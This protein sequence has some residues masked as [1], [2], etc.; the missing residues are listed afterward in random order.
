MTPDLPTKKPQTGTHY[1]GENVNGSPVIRISMDCPCD[2]DE[3]PFDGRNSFPRDSGMTCEN[4]GCTL[5]PN[6]IQYRLKGETHTAH[7]LVCPYGA[8]TV[9]CLD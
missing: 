2:C 3:C 8:E 9:R 6:P 4:C 7:N 5:D 1:T